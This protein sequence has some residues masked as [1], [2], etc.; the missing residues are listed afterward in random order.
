LQ[1]LLAGDKQQDAHEYFQSLL[2]QLHESCG[3]IA[4]AKACECLYHQTFFGRLRS[5]V[6][7]LTCHN[8]TKTS[9]P[10]IDLSLDLYQQAKRR[11]VDPKKPN[12]DAPLDL[13][14]CLKSF[15][16]PE[17]LQADEYRCG[18]ETCKKTTQ[19]AK[20][21]LTIKKLPPA[22]CIQLKRYEH[23]IVNAKKLTIRCNFPL[24][25]DMTPYTT[26]AFKQAQK[27]QKH[28]PNNSISSPL[29]TSNFP[30][31][32]SKIYDLSAVVVHHGEGTNAG[33]YKCF[34]K[35]DDQWFEYNDQKVML[36]SEKQVL[37]AEAYLLFYIVRDVG[38]MGEKKA[39]GE[40]GNGGVEKMEIGKDDDGGD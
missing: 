20:K 36:A 29:P 38:D 3:C 1:Q 26:A 15:T 27:Y 21:H 17:K 24:Q 14:S 4:P 9:D 40:R 39:V 13:W 5:T 2:N 33:H 34:C 31:S 10:I 19:R 8:V 23:N 37:G 18:S 6:T 11:K 7:C 25:L 12:V 22:M 32:L 16:T 28:N 30:S 35:R